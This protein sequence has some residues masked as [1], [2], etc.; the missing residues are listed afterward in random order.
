M[1][2]LIFPSFENTQSCTCGGAPVRFFCQG[3]IT[4]PFGNIYYLQRNFF[5][6]KITLSTKEIDMELTILNLVLITFVAGVVGGLVI[7]EEMDLETPE[8]RRRDRMMRREAKR[9]A[10]RAQQT[11]RMEKMRK[12]PTFTIDKF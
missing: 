1:S 2:S 10:R 6:V 4:A 7:A 8:R 11:R 5:H 9:Q 3:L 12:M